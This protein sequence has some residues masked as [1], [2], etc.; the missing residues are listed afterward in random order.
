MCCRAAGQCWRRCGRGPRRCCTRPRC[1]WFESQGAESFQGSPKQRPEDEGTDAINTPADG[2]RKGKNNDPLIAGRSTKNCGGCL[3]RREHHSLPW[4]PA[5]VILFAHVPVGAPLRNVALHQARTS[6]AYFHAEAGGFDTHGSGKADNGPFRR[7]VGR[8][9]RCRHQAGHGR[10]IDDVPK[11]LA[12]HHAIGR[13]RAMNDSKKIYVHDATEIL[14]VSIAQ[15]SHGG[16]G[17]VVEHEIQ[18]AMP[19]RGVTDQG[20]DLRRV[21]N[22]GLY[23]FDLSAALSNQRSHLL[24]GV[25]V[26]VGNYDAPAELGQSFTQGTPDARRAPGHDRR[27]IL[28]GTLWPSRFVHRGLSSSFIFCLTVSSILISGGQ[29]RLWP[30]PGS[31]WVASIPILLPMANSVVA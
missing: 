18:A 10:D 13:D 27:P 7:A 31:L 28:E 23:R 24:C 20:L 25:A 19:G 21:R 9:N 26:N 1:S 11:T 30:S 4:Q 6:D 16:D 5:K 29:P 3:G 8:K 2:C 12:Q 15:F 22:I 14:E 17:R